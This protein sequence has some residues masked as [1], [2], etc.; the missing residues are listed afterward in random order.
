VTVRRET[1][2]LI[3]ELKL[4]S[5]LDSNSSILDSGVLLLLKLV[6]IDTYYVIGLIL[7]ETR[8]RGNWKGLRKL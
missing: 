4:E 2:M 5:N 7:D 6:T 1:R 3:I 8:R